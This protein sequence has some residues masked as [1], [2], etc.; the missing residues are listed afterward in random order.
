DLPAIR[1]EYQRFIEALLAYQ[2][3]AL[4]IQPGDSSAQRQLARHANLHLLEVP[5]NDTWCRDYGPITLISSG[6]RRALDFLFNGWGGKYPAAL[7]N[8]VNTH[9]SRHPFFKG[10]EFRQSLFELEGGA[11]ECDGRGLLLINWHCLQTRHPHLDRDAIEYELRSLLNVSKVLGIDMQPTPGDDTDGHIDTLARFLPGQRI[12]F[13]DQGNN[14]RTSELRSQLE[15]LR[16]RSGHAFELIALP[17]PDGVDPALPANYVNFLFVNGACLVPVYG[18][19][20]DQQA[21][22]ILEQALPEHRIEAVPASQMIRQF[23]GLH[24]ASMHLPEAPP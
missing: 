20:A 1:S 2:S 13:Q 7:D 21:C 24:C 8:R 6:R 22:A 16:D 23:G 10:V 11:I 18:V 12:A 15:G 19:A 5:F 4:L 17:F 3:V 9:L 14:A